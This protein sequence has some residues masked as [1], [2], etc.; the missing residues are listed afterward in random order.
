MFKWKDREGEVV[1]ADRQGTQQMTNGGFMIDVGKNPKKIAVFELPID[2]LSYRSMQKE[3]VKD[4]RMVS[5]GGVKIE[6]VNH[7]VKDLR[8]QGH[9]IESIV[10]AVDN[11]KA[12]EQFHQKLKDHHGENRVVDHRPKNVKDWND[13]RK[14]QATSPKKQ[15]EPQMGM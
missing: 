11:D 12:G 6:S 10:P 15:Q 2:L 9:K 13:V 14:Q 8:S 4:T 7:A 3:K 5:M 1:G